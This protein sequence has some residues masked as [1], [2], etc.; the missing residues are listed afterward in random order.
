M[1]MRQLT[2]ASSLQSKLVELCKMVLH[3]EYSTDLGPS[4]FFLFSYLKKSLIMDNK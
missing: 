3:S 4:D 2:P 1:T